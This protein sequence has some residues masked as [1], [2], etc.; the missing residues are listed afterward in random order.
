MEWSTQRVGKAFRLSSI[1]SLGI[2]LS[3][4]AY[5]QSILRQLSLGLHLSYVPRSVYILYYQVVDSRKQV[6]RDR[7]FSKLGLE[8][9][10]RMMGE[11][12]AERRQAPRQYMRQAPS[13][14]CSDLDLNCSWGP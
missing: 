4:P 13:V 1:K 10:A 14:S 3:C 2:T 9:V 5:W 12:Q 7:V 11:T 6:C 8:E